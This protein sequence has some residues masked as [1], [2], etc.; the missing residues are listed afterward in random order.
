MNSSHSYLLLVLQ[1]YYNSISSRS[2]PHFA[3]IDLEL[4]LLLQ[5]YNYTLT[6]EFTLAVSFLILEF[7]SL[8]HQ[9]SSMATETVSSDHSTP[10]LEVIFTNFIV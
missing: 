7:L 6:T 2:D 9:E 8:H 3:L 4:L 5:V 10:A 1:L